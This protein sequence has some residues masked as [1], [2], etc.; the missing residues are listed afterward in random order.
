MKYNAN[1]VTGICGLFCETCPA[2]ADGACSGCLSDHVAERCA[3]CVHGFRDCA[4][5][6]GVVRCSV[7]ADFP[8]DRLRKFKDCH[9]V[10][11]ISHHEHILDYVKDQRDMGVEAWVKEQEALHVCPK[12][13]TMTVWCEKKCRGCG[14]EIKL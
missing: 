8:C 12:C 14:K 13:G 2:F 7:C 3:S 5:E 11:G 10:N 4:K 6:H 1:E 9:V